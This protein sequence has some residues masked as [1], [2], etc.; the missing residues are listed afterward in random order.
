M[1]TIRRLQQM[2]ALRKNNY[3][4]MNWKE[5]FYHFLQHFACGTNDRTLEAKKKKQMKRIN[6][7][8]QQRIRVN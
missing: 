1:Q 6:H 5:L 2:K 7:T 3:N 4:S 8:N